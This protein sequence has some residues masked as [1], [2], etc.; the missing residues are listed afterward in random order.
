[1]QLLKGKLNINFMGKRRIAIILSGILLTIALTALITR[2]LNFGID[3][4][5]GTLIEAGYPQAVELEPIRA[6]L[7]AS[8]FDGAQV[9]N[10]YNWIRYQICA[11]TS[12]SQPCK[13]SL[14][15]SDV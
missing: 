8:G 7:A 9:Q 14:P 6:T 1:M 12:H 10:F 11:A 5:G 4:T 13:H 3:F 15:Y 2:G